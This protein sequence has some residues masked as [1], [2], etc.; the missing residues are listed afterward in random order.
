MKWLFFIQ[1]SRDLIKQ[2]KKYIKKETENELKKYKEEKHP[3]PRLSNQKLNLYI[4]EVCELAKIDE[5]TTIVHYSGNNKIETTEPKYNLV[6]THSA[7]RTF[8][9]QSLLRG[10]KAEI[11]MSISGHKNY[12]T[13]QRYIDITRKDK[14]TE[15]KKAWDQN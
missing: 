7:R 4:K 8:I 5:I 11:V 2:D 12:K 3:L 15:L 1:A 6:T 14:E 10:M 9:T 13:F